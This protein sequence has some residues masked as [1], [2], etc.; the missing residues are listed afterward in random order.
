MLKEKLK[1]SEDELQLMYEN[2]ARFSKQIEE[3][4]IQL[5]KIKAEVDGY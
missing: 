4:N 3:S 1:K 2:D 5:H